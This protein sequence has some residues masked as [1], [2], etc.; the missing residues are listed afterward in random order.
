[1]LIVSADAHFTTKMPTK[2]LAADC[3]LTDEAG[4]L[5]VLDPPYK[6]TWDIPGGIVEVDEPPRRA[7]QREAHEEIG[8]DIEPGELLVVD[9]KPRDGDF[10]EVVALLFDGGTLTARDIDRIVIE[11][12]EVRG[13]RFVELDEAATLLDAELFARVAA[14]LTVRATGRMAY[15]E[16]GV[17]ASQTR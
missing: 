14:G 5:L 11:P 7:A 15:L 10:T 6:L 16:N 3:L 8:L 1:M 17:P 2:R 4:R 13:Y 9:W 12:S